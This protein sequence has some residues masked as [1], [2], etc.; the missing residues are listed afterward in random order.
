MP[1]K[2][3]VKTL[4]LNTFGVFLLGIGQVLGKFYYG[5]ARNYSKHIPYSERQI[6]D[7]AERLIFRDQL[8]S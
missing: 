3:Q 4:N 1:Q 6:Q 7:Y 2:N 5:T 8:I